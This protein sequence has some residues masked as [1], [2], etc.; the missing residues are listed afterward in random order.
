MF[1]LERSRRSGKE[2]WRSGLANPK[3]YPEGRKKLKYAGLHHPRPD[4]PLTEE[5]QKPL[6]E[7]RTTRGVMRTL[8]GL[9]LSSSQSNRAEEKEEGG[10]SKTHFQPSPR[11]VKPELELFSF[12]LTGTGL[13]AFHRVPS[14]LSSWRGGIRA[15]LVVSQDTAELHVTPSTVHRCRRAQRARISV[16]QGLSVSGRGCSI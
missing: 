1:S 6:E 9:F 3:R 15:D 7:A 11:H 4:S 13:K 16:L 8:T 12:H 2:A 5:E 10:K 14:A